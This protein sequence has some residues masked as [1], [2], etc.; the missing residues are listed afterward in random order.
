MLLKDV[1]ESVMT[2][3]GLDASDIVGSMHMADWPGRL[4]RQEVVCKYEPTR[5]CMPL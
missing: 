3:L 4:A 5:H 1:Q 2:L